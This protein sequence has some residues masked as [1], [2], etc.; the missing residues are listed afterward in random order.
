MGFTK[1]GLIVDTGV[2]VPP[3]IGS[4]EVEEEVEVSI[5]VVCVAG[6]ILAVGVDTSGV[7]LSVG[8]EIVVIV[9]FIGVELAGVAGF[10]KMIEPDT[11]IIFMSTVLPLA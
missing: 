3:T 9:A 8:E 6:N 4:N 10:G 1:V 7:K 5:T 11:V 2:E